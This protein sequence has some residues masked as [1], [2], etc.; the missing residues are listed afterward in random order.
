MKIVI[1][2]KNFKQGVFAVS[3]ITGKNNNL[4]IL[5]NLLIQAKDG[6]IK[7]ISTD[8]EMGV[9][10]AVR[11]K[12]ETEGAITI[13]AKLLANYINLLPNKKIE[14]TAQ[15]NILKIDAENY[16]TKINGEPADD[17][18]LIPEVSRNEIYHVK[19]NEFKEA[20][21]AVAFAAATDSSRPN[22]TGILLTIE[23]DKLTL[24]GTDS[25][26]LAEKTLTIKNNGTGHPE[27]ASGEEERRVI[28]PLRSL[29][30]LVRILNGDYS[31][32][33]DSDEIEIVLNDNQIMFSFNSVEIVSRLIDEKYPDYK[34]I[35]PVNHKTLATVDREE[36]IRAVK[37]SAIFSKSGVNDVILDFKG[38]NLMISAASGLAGENITTLPV[39]VEGIENSVTINYRYLLDGLNTIKSSLVNIEL[40]DANTACIL[41]PAENGDYLYIIMPIKR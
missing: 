28:V 7:L 5:N 41:K 36:L 1:L 12:I 6:A 18:P 11:G 26:R 17:Y 31:D 10:S 15:N 37:T 8:L 25:Y 40:I 39:K 14:A 35:I 32:E 29:L 13:N 24:V 33:T 30:E 22:L 20:V 9:V 23:G 16:Q 3:Y 27:A 38:E 19:I 4:P 34:Q 2:Q 21:G